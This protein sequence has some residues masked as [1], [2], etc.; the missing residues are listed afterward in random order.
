MPRPLGGTLLGAGAVLVWNAVVEQGRDQFYEWHDKGHIPER[1]VIPGFRRG[2]RYAK[3]GH[4]PEFRRIR[5]IGPCCRLA[6]NRYHCSSAS[7]DNP[8]RKEFLSQHADKE[9]GIQCQ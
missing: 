2:R 9:V 1:L 5:Y 3:H 6:A 4:S 7:R 8:F